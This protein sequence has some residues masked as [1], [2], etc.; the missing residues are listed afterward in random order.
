MAQRWL[1]QYLDDKQREVAQKAAN[2]GKQHLSMQEVA[3]FKSHDDVY[4]YLHLD[5]KDIYFL[6]VPI[7][8]NLMPEYLCMHERAKDKSFHWLDRLEEQSYTIIA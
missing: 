7:L 4:E 5:T 2:N 1:G 6:W 3:P 8:C